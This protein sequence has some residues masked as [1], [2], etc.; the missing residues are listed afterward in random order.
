MI[1]LLGLLLPRYCI[2]YPAEGVDFQEAETVANAGL[3]GRRGH[4]RETSAAAD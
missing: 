4:L 1:V 2:E 3:I